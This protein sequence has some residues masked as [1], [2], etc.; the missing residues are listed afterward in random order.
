MG[1]AYYHKKE[2]KAN[3]P[4]IVTKEKSTNMF[5]LID[6][7]VPSYRNVAAKEVEKISKYKDL[8][9]EVIKM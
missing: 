8:K 7:A 4:D 5:T 6:M 1:Y 2:I 3:R 9:I